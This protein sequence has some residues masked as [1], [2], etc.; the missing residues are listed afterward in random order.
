MKIDEID[1]MNRIQKLNFYPQMNLISQPF[2]SGSFV[3]LI[4]TLYIYNILNLN[5]I[6]LITKL[7]TIAALLKLIF[8]RKRPYHMSNTIINYTN[9]NHDSLLN[10]FSFP[11][12]HTFSSTIFCLLMLKKYPNEFVFNIIAILVGFSRVFLGVHYPTDIIGGM[13]FGFLF[14]NI[15]DDSS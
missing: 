14:Y 4:A 7:V 9:K 12:G 11:S 5:D 15:L 3:V 6:I 2:N 13:V 10:V 1:L 8:R